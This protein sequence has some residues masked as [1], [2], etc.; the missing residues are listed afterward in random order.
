MGFGVSGLL[1]SSREMR[2][3]GET[4]NLQKGDDS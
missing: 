3:E 2:D 1:I 4:L